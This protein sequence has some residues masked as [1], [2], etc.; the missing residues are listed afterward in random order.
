MPLRRDD[1]N[2]GY[3]TLPIIVIVR[4]TRFPFFYSHYIFLVSFSKVK[5]Q[6]AVHR[7]HWNPYNKLDEGRRRLISN[8]WKVDV[9][10]ISYM[11][12][13][14]Q[15]ISQV[16]FLLCVTGGELRT[17]IKLK[18]RTQTRTRRDIKRKEK[19]KE[20]FRSVI[21]PLVSF[22]SETEQLG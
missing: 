20:M 3:T 7:T 19:E 22:L 9:P 12:F 1:H 2:D 21:R 6:T 13:Q 10:D 15:E 5:I 16:I 14:G 17:Q 11:L 4:H 18:K 8:S